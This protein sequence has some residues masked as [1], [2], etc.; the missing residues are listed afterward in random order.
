MG[1]FA[2]GAIPNVI[3]DSGTDEVTSSVAIVAQQRRT[4]GKETQTALGRDTLTLSRQG[5]VRWITPSPTATAGQ[6][7]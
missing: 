2:L 7:K 4:S 6:A 3:G 5:R 1:Q